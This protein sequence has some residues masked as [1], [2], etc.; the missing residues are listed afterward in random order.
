MTIERQTYDDVQSTLSSVKPG[1]SRGHSPVTLGNAADDA[2][3]GHAGWHGDTLTFTGEGRRNYW[4]I[5]A[6]ES[7]VSFAVLVPDTLA[8]GGYVVSDNYGGCEYHVAVNSSTME[9]ALLHVFRG[10]SGLT[11][12]SLGPGWVMKAILRSHD[13]VAKI[14][15][16]VNNPGQR[17]GSVLS[18]SYIPP[19]RIWKNF[20]IENEFICVK[21]GIVTHALWSDIRDSVIG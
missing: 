5:P 21:A 13:L 12:Y 2:R 9:L 15:Y 18:I 4:F 16:K 7:S 8:I 6:V 17:D 3:C 1:M 11:K 19:C 10:A 14:P 20:K